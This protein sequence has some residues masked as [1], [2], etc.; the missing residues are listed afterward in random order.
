ML[1]KIGVIGGGNIGG[2]LIQELARRNLAKN[3][4]LVD[5]KEPDLA[6]GKCLDVSEGKPIINSDV[7]LLGSRTYEILEGSDIIINTASVPRTVRPDGTIPTREELLTTNLKITDTVCKGIKNYCPGATIVSIANP[8]CAILYRMKNNLSPPR[9][10]I[11]GMGGVLDS[12]RYR[13]F[14]AHEANVSVENVQALVLGGHGDDMVPIR[15][16]CTIAGLSIEK[17][18]SPKKLDEIENRVR[19]AGGEIVN[20]MGTGSAF[21][22]PAWGALE[23]VE[24]IALDRK[25]IISCCVYLEGEYGIDGVFFGVPVVLGKMGAEKIIEIDL[26]DSEKKAL[27]KSVEFSRE[28]INEINSGK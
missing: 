25:K 18:I 1:Y 10:K 17:F 28:V 2:S 5:I 19:F 4:A 15:S 20:L 13:Y 7:E 27:E 22:S 6:K 23:M 21:V 26:S 8:L 3:A 16:A 12:S 11:I 24:A 14:I 9:N